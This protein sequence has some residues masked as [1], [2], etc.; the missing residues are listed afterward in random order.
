[1]RI[2]DIDNP[3]T[4]Q[5][6]CHA[7]LVAEYGMDFQVVDDSGGDAGND[8]YLRS[9]ATLFAIY[10]PEKTINTSRLKSKIKGDLNKA[11][12]LRDEKSYEI[13]KWVFVTP[14]ELREPL[15]RFVRD[16]AK[17]EDLVGLCMAEQH[18]QDM[19]LRHKYLHDKFPDLISPSVVAGL[20][21]VKE[22]LDDL[23]DEIHKVS[24]EGSVKSRI[25]STMPDFYPSEEFLVAQELLFSIDARKG[26]E[27]LERLRLE[28]KSDLERLHATILIIQS[29]NKAVDIDRL[30]QLT[31]EALAQAEQLNYYVA[32]VGMKSELGW[33]LN[34]R[35]IDLDMETYYRGLMSY[36]IG[37]PF[38]T[39]E[40]RKNIETKLHALFADSKKVFDEALTLA[41]NKG[42]Y[43]EFALSLLL[44]ANAATQRIIFYQKIP[45]LSERVR[46]DKQAVLKSYETSIRIAVGL[47]DAYL[48][49]QIY[50]NYANDIRMFGE[51]DQART[52]SKYAKDIAKKNGFK[53][54]I[55][56]SDELKKI[57]G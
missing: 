20:A 27:Q 19:F 25:S 35:Y 49:A 21:E 10:C 2:R 34:T 30:E 15:Q 12:K 24:V 23:R 38:L 52:Y 57:I 51:L 22:G 50:H 48:L 45:S 28:A 31:I 7:L 56:M 40:E 4:F 46:L 32:I 43:R 33:I 9:Q 53:D 1:M 47:S 8:G 37:F 16:E 26:L 54:I 5:R 44:Y 6:L 41:Q 13:K 18:L 17:D 39:E 11:V 14:Y 42:L 36:T 29:L 3:E 55:I